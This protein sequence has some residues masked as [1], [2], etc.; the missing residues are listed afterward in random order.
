MSQFINNTFIYDPARSR[1]DFGPRHTLGNTHFSPSESGIDPDIELET[2]GE[3]HCRTA[4]P[5]EIA[6]VEGGYAHLGQ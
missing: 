2:T 5:Q 1:W 3:H 4:S 6:R